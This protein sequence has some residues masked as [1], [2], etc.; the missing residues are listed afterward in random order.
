[1]KKRETLRFRCRIRGVIES[2]TFVA[3]RS[4]KPFLECMATEQ[5]YLVE[6][7]AFVDSAGTKSPSLK[8]K[9]N[10]NTEPSDF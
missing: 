5:Y 8:E 4:V 10:A 9:K 7:K 6:C 1:M 3:I 2:F